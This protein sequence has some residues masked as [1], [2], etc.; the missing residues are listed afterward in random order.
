VTPPHSSSQ[1][2]RARNP[3][4]TSEEDDKAPLSW[5][6][7]RLLALL[8]FPSL[9][10][11]FA[12]TAT[13]TYVPVLVEQVSGPLM[14]GLLV[15]GEGFFGIFV[16]L[17]VGGWA[18]R[19]P[20]VGGRLGW[21]IGAAVLLVAAVATVGALG[22]L[23]AAPWLFAIALS[24]LYVGYYGYLAPY[25]ALYPDLVPDN[26]SGRSP[27]AGS[28]WRVTGVGLALIGGGSARW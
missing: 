22:E 28:S 10:L 6:E 18:D 23:S 11:A 25:W 1:T 4:A 24:A 27:S 8:G 13:S 16:P 9:G 2:D 21:A 5:P 19:W 14:V 3:D 17:L 20:T 7:R 26:E 12:V 15:G